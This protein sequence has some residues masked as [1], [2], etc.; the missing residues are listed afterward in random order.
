[1]IVFTAFGQLG[2]RAKV[3]AREALRQAEEYLAANVPV[4]R[5]PA[6]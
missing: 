3:V 4:G 1:M 6:D 2:I 5:H